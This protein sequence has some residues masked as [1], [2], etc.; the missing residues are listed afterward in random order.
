MQTQLQF[1]P[2]MQHCFIGT[3]KSAG[4]RC[5]GTVAHS[6]LCNTMLHM[7][8]N[9]PTHARPVPAFPSTHTSA[10]PCAQRTTAKPTHGYLAWVWWRIEARPAPGALQASAKLRQST[11]TAR[12]WANLSK[13]LDEGDYCGV[14]HEINLQRSCLCWKNSHMSFVSQLPARV[15][16]LACAVTVEISSG[17]RIKKT[18]SPDRQ[19]FHLKLLPRCLG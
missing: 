10:H 13:V 6:A 9:T 7:H 2:K 17:I 19:A 15:A 16:S 1:H 18:Q 4:M 11:D 5:L 3:P 12:T 14:V 8:A